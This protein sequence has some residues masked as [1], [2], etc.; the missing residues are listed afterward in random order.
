ML[1]KYTFVNLFLMADALQCTV[2]Q[3]SRPI[4]SVIETASRLVQQSACS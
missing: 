4:L 3:F 2:P 1:F